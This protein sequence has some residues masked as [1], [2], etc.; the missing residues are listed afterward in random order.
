M[1]I[2]RDLGAESLDGRNGARRDER[3]DV[4]DE[5]KQAFAPH[6]RPHYGCPIYKFAH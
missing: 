6:A 5:I 4:R 3:G 2:E 1:E